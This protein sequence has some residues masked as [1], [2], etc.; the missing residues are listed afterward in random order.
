MGEFLS[1]ILPDNDFAHLT[2][3]VCHIYAENLGASLFVGR[4]ELDIIFLESG[5]GREFITGDQPIVNLLG[6][7]D[8]SAPEDLAF[9]YPLSPVL[10]CLVSSKK[11]GLLGGE[12]PCG[13]VEGLNEL[14]SWESKQFLGLA[15]I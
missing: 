11:Y 8:G 9:Y 2:N 7:G 15:L 5:N 6:T 10:S 14:I 12:I 3:I 1:Q 13:I 4:N